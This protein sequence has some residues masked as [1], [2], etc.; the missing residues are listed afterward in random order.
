MLSW[1][2][3]SFVEP[4]PP[5]AVSLHEYT[6]GYSVEPSKFTTQQTFSKN[7]KVRLFDGVREY[8]L[9]VAGADG[10]GKSAIVSQF[11][12]G[13]MKDNYV[14]LP[15]TNDHKI[16]VIDGETVI[17]HVLD[18]TRQ[19]EYTMMPEQDVR[20]GEA[21]LL[22]YSIKSRGTFTGI[23]I[24]HQQ[25]KKVKGRAHCPLVLLGNHS[26]QHREREVS[27]Q[28]AEALAK[29]LGCDFYEVSSQQHDRISAAF[30]A[31]IKDIRTHDLH[32]K[33]Q[34]ARAK[35]TSARVRNMYPEPSYTY[36]TPGIGVKP[37]LFR[38]SPSLRYPLGYNFPPGG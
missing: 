26:D 25:I 2:Q 5:Y 29:S 4:A 33:Q 21:F 10:I 27:T 12:T 15:N 6:R 22:V 37:Y 24:L 23:T 13:T 19:E 32:I 1:E 3:G 35:A 17:G 20:T 7:P 11:I 34:I 8:K 36:D 31:L 30:D 9:V 14:L 18:T 38:R 28:E 16:C